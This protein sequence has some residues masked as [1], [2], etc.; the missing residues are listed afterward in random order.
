LSYNLDSSF[1]RDQNRLLVLAALRGRRQMTRSDLARKTN[2]SYP[3]VATILGQLQEEGFLRASQPDRR[4]AGRRPMGVEFNPRARLVAGVDLNT[5]VP[6]VVLTDL[7]GEPVGQVVTG[8]PV[9]RAEELVPS[10]TAGVAKALSGQGVEET[11]LL[12]VG[13]ALRGTLD[14]EHEAAHFMEFEPAVRLVPALR[15]RF[16]APVILDH[17]YNAA[18]LAEHLYGAARGCAL[19]YRVNVGTGI[20]AGVLV[21]GEIYRGAFG[22]AGEFGHVAVD[23]QGPVCQGCGRH[24]CLELYASARAIA[25]KA[26]GE[27][28]DEGV[29]QAVEELA[30]RA[31]AGD[32]AARQ[33]FDAAAWALAEGLADVVNVLNPEMVIVDGSVV[34]SYPPLAAE[35]HRR[36]IETVWPP[37]RSHL[38][39]ETSQ[40]DGPVPVMLRGAVALILHEVFRIPAA[41][42][43]YR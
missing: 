15:E 14:L 29:D 13:V 3:T 21:Q 18:L 10:V 8:R 17:N 7:D 37:S 42:S 40:L 32:E 30:R 22:N 1:V 36:L 6:R 23:P 39:I 19:V 41:R 9:R 43:E 5:P 33:V 11:M 31:L 16:Q 35:V 27:V 24:G 25:R 20:S 4:A 38:R 34:R 26:G 2:L 28:P 12:G